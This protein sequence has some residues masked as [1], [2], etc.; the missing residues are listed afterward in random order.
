MSETISIPDEATY[1]PDLA[2]IF[3]ALH[4]KYKN[5]IVMV[6]GLLTI[7]QEW[8]FSTTLGPDDIIDLAYQTSTFFTIN[9]G[10]KVFFRCKLKDFYDYDD[11]EHDFIF[12][13]NPDLKI[14]I[15]DSDTCPM[16]IEK[17]KEG[18]EKFKAKKIIN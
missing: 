9:G 2:E 8:D 5:I 12:Y 1:L 4:E 15:R 16:Y 6:N 7:T 10:K 18:F 11:N 17:D 13:V 14:H 3:Y